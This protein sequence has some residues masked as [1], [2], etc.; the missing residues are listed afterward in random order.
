[1]TCL[2]LIPPGPL[3]S[4]F[5]P[6][7]V[8]Q[9]SGWCCFFACYLCSAFEAILYHLT[10]SLQHI[11]NLSVYQHRK[12]MVPHEHCFLLQSLFFFSFTSDELTVFGNCILIFIS[13]SSWTHCS[14][15][16]ESI[17]QWNRSIKAQQNIMASDSHLTAPKEV[18]THPEIFS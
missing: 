1:M 6:I 2:I 5:F 11:I 17:L 3:E 8:C 12:A 10:S 4:C 18:S 7:N 9:P 14:L 13:I 16:S 15:K